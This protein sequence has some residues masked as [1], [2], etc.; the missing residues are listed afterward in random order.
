MIGAWLVSSQ[1]LLA[2]KTFAMFSFM[3]IFNVNVS[4][5]LPPLLSQFCLMF[6]RTVTTVPCML[7]VKYTSRDTIN[8]G[9]SG[10]TNVDS[11]ENEQNAGFR[12]K[13][14][15]LTFS[16]Y[17]QRSMIEVPFCHYV[18]SVISGYSRFYMQEP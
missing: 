15:M 6:T 11:H 13:R 2:V 5:G 1:R 9:K 17:L 12:H 7:S 10:I 14:H 3:C 4:V 8:F 18:G 16:L